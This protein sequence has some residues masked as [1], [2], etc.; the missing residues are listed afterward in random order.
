MSTQL[1]LDDELSG[2]VDLIGRDTG[3]SE[4]DIIRSAL[5]EK[6]DR[7]IRERA[8]AG[9]IAELR[10][11][12]ERLTPPSGAGSYKTNAESDAWMYDE[13]GLPH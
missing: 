2:V 4:P 11:I 3:L 8:A 9:R 6:L 5:I 13:H 12:L 10:I 1:T 7:I